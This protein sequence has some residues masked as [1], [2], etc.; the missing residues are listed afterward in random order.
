MT[1][2]EKKENEYPKL[3]LFKHGNYEL[4]ERENV[5]IKFG[6]GKDFEKFIKNPDLTIEIW[7]YMDT[8]PHSVGLDTALIRF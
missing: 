7:G 5:L 1:E 6:Y 3:I 4:Y 8:D 2:K